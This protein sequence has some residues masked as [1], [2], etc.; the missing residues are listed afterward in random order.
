MGLHCTDQNPYET[1]PKAGMAVRGDLMTKYEWPLKCKKCLLSA[2]NL[3]GTCLISAL[4]LPG[5]PP[6]KSRQCKRGNTQGGM[7]KRRGSQ[8]TRVVGSGWGPRINQE[9]SR[10]E[11]T[12]GLMMIRSL[13]Q[14]RER[15]L[16]QEEE[17][18]RPAGARPVG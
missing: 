17:R 18:A 9:H 10:K 15:R 3:P 14:N 7:D 4:G 2:V 13:G 5:S 16:S 12:G 6:H 8:R 1:L 11:M